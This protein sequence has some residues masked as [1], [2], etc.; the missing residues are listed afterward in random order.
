M[1]N[2]KKTFDKIFMIISNLLKDSVDK[3]GNFP[4]IG[5]NPKFSYIEV[6]ALSLTSETLSI[7]SEN[8]LFCKLNS[9]YKKQFP[10]LIN[11]SKYNIRR[12]NLAYKFASN[13]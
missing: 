13:F 12:R 4:K 1:H 8:Y 2:I 9:E 6:I 5:R 10:N 3:K 7:D 11:R